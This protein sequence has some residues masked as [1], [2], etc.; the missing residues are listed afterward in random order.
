MFTAPQGG[1]KGNDQIGSKNVV[2]FGQVFL[3]RRIRGGS[4]QCCR[5]KE[6]KSGI[7]SSKDRHQS[8]LQRNRLQK[9][10]CTSWGSSR[11]Y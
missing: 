10:R 11:K 8:E 1:N 7:R 4:S 6:S 5:H 2:I 9:N 3:N